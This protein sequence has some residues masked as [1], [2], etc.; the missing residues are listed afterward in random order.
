MMRIAAKRRVRVIAASVVAGAAVVLAGCGSSSVSPAVVPNVTGLTPG[1]AIDVL[2]S[3]GF[4]VAHTIYVAGKSTPQY[5]ASPAS[6]QATEFG[7]GLG[8]VDSTDPTPGTGVA[9]GSVV[10]LHTSGSSLTLYASNR[11]CAQ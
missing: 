5:E 7:L 6:K 3:D 8:R 4:R 2:C 9:R 11:G 10:T 1:R